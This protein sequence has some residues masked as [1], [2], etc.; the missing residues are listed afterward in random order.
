MEPILLEFKESDF[1]SFGL[2]AEDAKR[3]LQTFIDNVNAIC[4][5]KFTDE[6]LRDLVQGNGKQVEAT[7]SK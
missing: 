2:K 5:V 6:L 3:Y 7:I 1:L 4:P